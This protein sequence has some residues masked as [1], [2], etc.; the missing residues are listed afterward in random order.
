MHLLL[1]VTHQQDGLP[2]VLLQLRAHGLHPASNT[3]GV[4]VDL[5]DPDAHTVQAAQQFPGFRLVVDVV[6]CE[7]QQCG[8]DRKVHHPI[9]VHHAE[10]IE[11]GE[12]L[13]A[14]RRGQPASGQRQQQDGS[15]Q[16]S[17]EEVS[18]S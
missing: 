7:M 9:S 15:G 3:A 8:P 13:V 10:R 18:P 16:K 2:A 6:G 4:T 12:P 14:A 11:I 1:L 5:V 17:H